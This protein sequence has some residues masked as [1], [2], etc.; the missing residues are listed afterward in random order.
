MLCAHCFS[1][2]EYLSSESSSLFIMYS[3]SCWE[4]PSLEAKMVHVSWHSGSLS[5]SISRMANLCAC[6]RCWRSTSV[7]GR[8]LDSKAVKF[9]VQIITITGCN[10]K[11]LKDHLFDRFYAESTMAVASWLLTGADSSHSQLTFTCTLKDQ[12]CNTALFMSAD[13]SHEPKHDNMHWWHF[14]FLMGKIRDLQWTVT[15]HE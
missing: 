8:D 9:K 15:I 2:R 12:V 4:S 14:L 5:L 11:L 10:L 3:I 13:S 7:D 1:A 6:D